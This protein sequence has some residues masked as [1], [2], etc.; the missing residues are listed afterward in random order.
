[1]A[2]CAAG[3]DWRILGFLDDDPQR[4]GDEYLGLPVMGDSGWIGDHPEVRVVMGIGHPHPRRQ[5]ALR[6]S[7]CG[8]RWATVV[9]PMAVVVPSATIGNG[10]VLF[11]GAVVSS[12]SKLGQLVQVS[13]HAVIHHDSSVGD[14]ACVMGHAIL[15]GSVSVGEG[16]FIGMSTSVRQGISIGAGTIVGC[17]SSVVEDLPSYCVAVGVPS[18]VIRQYTSSEEMPSI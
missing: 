8:V 6:L 11:A 3:A 14:Y 7:A 2:A 5:A 15:G 18:R 16:S 1:M 17:G 4:Q 12:D 10:C 9:H 13:Y